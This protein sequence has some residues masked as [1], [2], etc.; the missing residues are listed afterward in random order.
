M[1]YYFSGTGNTR[2]V[3]EQVSRACGLALRNVADCLDD[4]AAPVGN[5]WTEGILGLAF[6]IYGWTIPKVAEAFIRSLPRAEA[7]APNYVFA[8][9]TCGDDIGRAHER[10]AMLLA[11]KGYELSAVWSFSMPNTYIGLPFFDVDNEEL[12][13]RKIKS[14]QEKLPRVA[15]Q[16]LCREKGVVDVV[17]GS[18]SRWKSGW[19]RQFFYRF[20]VGPKM[21]S[22]RHRCTACQ[23]CEKVC[24]L[25]NIKVERPETGPKWGRQCTF[26]LACYHVCPISNILV[27][28][29]GANKGRY[30]H[31]LEAKP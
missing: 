10:L 21:F 14:T 23:R 24:P 5:L 6:P 12:A 17:P 13:A 20:W 31:F 8:L 29:S 3:A 2:W 7:P 1:I 26:C 11:E 9:L 16:I 4:V 19:L 27:G 15:Q 25:H 30:T 22:T 28:P 18:F